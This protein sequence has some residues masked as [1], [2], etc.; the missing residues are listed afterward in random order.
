MSAK[1]R[2]LQSLKLLW[3]SRILC[4]RAVRAGFHGE[5]VVEAIVAVCVGFRSLIVYRQAYES[6]VVKAKDSEGY[7]RLL[8]AVNLVCDLCV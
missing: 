6:S 7:E 5:M 4:E 3:V 1:V 8:Y 2:K